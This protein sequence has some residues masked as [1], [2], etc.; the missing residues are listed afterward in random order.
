MIL[1]S[2]YTRFFHF[3]LI[4]FLIII[5]YSN[6]LQSPWHFDD[7]PNIVERKEIHWEKITLDSIK[8][9]FFRDGY[10][11]KNISR[12]IPRLTF[13][14]NYYLTG[15]NTLS[16]HLT[17]ISI[18]I[19][20]ALFAYLVFLKTL[21]LLKTKEDVNFSF[22]TCQEIAL[23][24]AVL[25]AIHPLQTQA[26]TYIVQRMASMAAM[27]YIMGMFFYIQGRLTAGY[28]TFLFLSV[29]IVCWIFGI[30]SKEN[31][32][33]LPLS[34]IIYE[35]IFFGLTRKKIILIISL[36]LCF[37]IGI[38]S[39][40]L[41]TRGTYSGSFSDIYTAIIDKI[42]KPY[43]N[44]PFTMEERL[45]TE[46]RILVWY[47]FLIVCPVSDFL[48][49]ESDIVVSSGL[50]SPITTFISILLILTIILYSIFYS[51][52]LKIISFAF[53][54]FFINH[55]VE[56]TI[57]GL[58]LYFEHR[59][60]LPS[61]F[62][63]LAISY[64]LLY[65]YSYLH[66]NKKILAKIFIAIFIVGILVSQG[67]ATYLRNDI[68]RN[69]IF[70]M[71]DAIKKA[72]ENI[73]PY[74]SVSTFYM[75]LKMFD[76]A[77]HYLKEA[78]NLYKKDPERYQVNFPALL[79]YTAAT[80]YTYEWERKDIDKA[81]SLLYKSCELFPV[82]YLAH[83]AL[84]ALLFQKG[85][86]QQAEQAMINASLL[87]ED[88]SP[89]F[90]SNFGRVLYSN[91]KIDEA[92]SA[93][94]AGLEIKSSDTLRLNLIAAY[95]KKGDIQKAKNILY[96]I[97]ND[98]D[99]PAYLLNYVLL[100]S[101]EKGDF[102]LEKLTSLLVEH[103]VSYCEWI[104]KIHSNNLLGIIY[105]DIKSIEARIKTKYFDHLNIDRNKIDEII[106]KEATCNFN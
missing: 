99:S 90:Y 85:E 26:V 79:Y 101:D 87:E 68:W 106:I 73:R 71:E 25:W 17:N 38:I 63:Y 89:V 50:F 62:I 61:M 65:T 1:D 9:T 41:F 105:P 86:Y 49:L 30:L 74:I 56:S 48:S 78:E 43:I 57:V 69:E 33:L 27:F 66:N 28:K 60:Y 88:L 22:I 44:R 40:L 4:S 59:N 102:A 12:P 10:G 46:P 76:K 54:F 77:R 34:I 8:E 58:E 39:V 103:R 82:D 11:G 31:A 3:F 83:A 13:A 92:I 96:E 97:P 20:T 91:G 100:N 16:Y 32:V 84:G 7:F 72:P 42:L 19:I 35:L 36:T 21:V 24:G 64:Y 18:H 37:I 52:K 51:S 70:L 80:L 6:T 2:F 5:C 75:R 98:N 23:I 15:L 14:F 29:T 55:M 81:I 93:F 104:E 95:L 53:L 47:L 94:I 67:N 45:L